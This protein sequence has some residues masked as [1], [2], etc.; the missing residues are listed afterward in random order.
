[1]LAQRYPDAYNGIAAAAPAIDWAHFIPATS[2]AQVIMP[3]TGQYPTKCEI[4]ALTDAAIAA[5]DPL[6]GV[7]D[8]EPLPRLFVKKDPAW[9]YSKIASVDEYAAQFHA[10]VQEYDSIIGSADP[11]LSAFRDAD[12]TEDYYKRVNDTTPRI[13]D[14]FRYFEVPGLAHCSGGT[15]GQH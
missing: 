11:D 4:D 10:G 5:C 12:G 1:M 15:G 3:I 6:D 7:T 2:W 14:F 8:G 13:V 9:D